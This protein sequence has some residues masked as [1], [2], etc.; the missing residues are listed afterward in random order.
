MTTTA[1]AVPGYDCTIDELMVVELARRFDD[2][3]RAFNG[4]V[5]FIPVCAGGCSV[6][7]H[8]ELG[9]LDTPACHRHSIE[10]ALVS[11]AAEAAA[12]S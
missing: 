7:S 1:P 3:T 10:S 8:A 9:D 4:A 12:A 11:Y 5:S 6:A 2:S